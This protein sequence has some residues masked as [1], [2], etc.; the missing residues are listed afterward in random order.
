MKTH[1]LR[2]LI[3]SESHFALGTWVGWVITWLYLGFTGTMKFIQTSEN[4][5]TVNEFILIN[6]LPIIFIIWNIHIIRSS[7]KLFPKIRDNFG[8]FVAGAGAI[9]VIMILIVL[10][11]FR[12]IS[13]FVLFG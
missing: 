6:F 13:D 7:P 12:S 11:F 8:S 9:V 10:P 2:H 3:K 4:G 5:I 1:P